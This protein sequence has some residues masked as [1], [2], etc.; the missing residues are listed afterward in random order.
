MRN[1]IPLGCVFV[2]RYLQA[3]RFGYAPFRFAP[4]HLFCI[5]AYT[6]QIP[7][8][9]PSHLLRDNLYIISFFSWCCADLLWNC[10]RT[11]I[12]LKNSFLILY[13][14]WASVRLAHCFFVAVLAREKVFGVSGWAPVVCGNLWK[15][16]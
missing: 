9:I 14:V 7:N 15:F 11:E 2:I 1:R 13:N 5:P 12:F 4:L 3:F 16:V 8:G 10:C 6:H